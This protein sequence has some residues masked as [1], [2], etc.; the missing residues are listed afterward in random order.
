[1]LCCDEW[2]VLFISQIMFYL[3]IYWW[4]LWFFISTLQL[5]EFV[6]VLR[7]YTCRC[8]VWT[9]WQKDLGIINLCL[10]FPHF[11]QMCKQFSL[12]LR[13]LST[14]KN[15]RLSRVQA[16]EVQKENRK[17]IYSGKQ[18]SSASTCEFTWLILNPKPSEVWNESKTCGA[19][20]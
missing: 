2:K 20:K 12:L 13:K 14:T 5:V 10:A 17:H 19:G 6:W 18:L 3:I 11:L 15:G 16:E 9:N 8:K 1:M 4:L 7:L